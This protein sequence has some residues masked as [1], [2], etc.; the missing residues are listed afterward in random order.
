MDKACKG[1]LREVLKNGDMEG[2]IGQTLMLPAVPGAG[3]KRILLV[4]CGKESEMNERS[5]IRV[6]NSIAAADVVLRFLMMSSA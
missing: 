3:A 6:I 5:Y 4:G 1:Y 2:K